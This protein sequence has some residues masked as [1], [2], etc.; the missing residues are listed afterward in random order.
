MPSSAFPLVDAADIVRLVGRGAYDRG[1]AYARGESVL[2][3][4]WKPDARAGA[5]P[6]E[7]GAA[8]EPVDESP[9]GSGGALAAEVVGTGPLPYLCRV[10]LTRMANGYWLPL[11]S[12]CSCPV[13]SN[14]KHVAATLLSSNQAHLRDLGHAEGGALAAPRAHLPADVGEGGARRLRALDGEEG[15]S[16]PDVAPTPA[17][18]PKPSPEPTAGPLDVESHADAAMAWDRGTE[19]YPSLAPAVIRRPEVD[20][21][22]WRAIVGGA[23]GAAN[24][25]GAGAAAT[26]RTGSAGRTRGGPPRPPTRMG[27]QFEVREFVPRTRE[28]WRGPASRPAQVAKSRDDTI[29]QPP[30]RLGVRPVIRSES[31][32]YIKA[33]VTWSS[34]THQV[35]RLNLEPEH[36]RWFAQF[37]AVHRATRELY[38]GHETDWLYLDEFT[39][40]L[41]WHLLDEGRALGIPLLGTKKSAVVTRGSEGAVRLDAT[42]APSGALQLAAVAVID[43]TAAP[44]QSVG[45]IGAHGVYTYELAPVPRVSIAPV[46]AGLS[47]QALALLERNTDIVVPGDEVGEFI[48]EFLPRLR[49]AIDVG[50]PDESV[51]LPEVMPPVLVL[52]AR[53]RAKSVLSL[54]WSWEYAVGPRA[55]RV[56]LYAAAGMGSRDGVEGGEGDAEDDGGV[57]RDPVTERETLTR[58]T[59]VLAEEPDGASIEALDSLGD[60]DAAAPEPLN[61]SL[62]LR[63]YD[64]AIFTD[65]TLPRLEGLPGVRVDV[66]GTRPDYRELTGEPELT[67]TTVESDKRD[68]F[69]LGV[70]VNVGG[71]QVPFGPLFKAL[72]KNQKKLLMVDKTYLT[73]DHPVFDQLREL[74]DEAS[75]L[76]EWETGVRISRYQASLW[77][78]FEELA[79]DTVQAVAWREAV[80]G[81]NGLKGVPKPEVPPGVHANLR[82]YQVEGYQWLAFLEQQRLG[83]VLA[84]D[85]GLGKTLQTLAMLARARA[86]APD[87]APFL[88][89]APTSVVSNWLAEAA[90]FTPGLVVRGITSTQAKSRRSVADAAAG[91]DVIVTSYAL[92]RLDA[93]AYRAVEWSGLIL[94]EAQFVK[95]H[96][97]KLH[98]CAKELDA[99]FKLAITGTP[100]ENNLMEL[101]SLFDIVAPGLFPSA[102][103]FTEEYVRPIERMLDDSLM[104]KLR[105][106]IRP[107]MM[108]RTKQLVA[109]ELP[110]KQEQVLQI[111][112]APAHRR[113]YDAFFQKERQKLLGLVDDLDKNRFIVFRS[114]TL[115]RMLSLDASLIDEKYSSIPSSKLDAL[116]EQ[117]GDVVAEGHR[118]LMFSQFTSFLG[119]A[120]AR[121][122]DAGIAFE[123]LDGSTRNRAQV[124]DG[125]K[126]G[127]APVFLISLKAGGFGL[128]LTE[129]DYVF[130]LDPWWNP[131]SESQAIDRTHR[132]GQTKSVNVYRLVA[133]DTIE[134]KVMALKEQKSK[135]FDA[136]MDD[137]AVFSSALTAADIRGLLE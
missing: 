136:V 9:T 82:P 123:Y 124:I 89:V 39:S 85:M 35:N 56:P 127:S 120:A 46:A 90:R 17:P 81:L 113:L 75:T 36:L 58:V 63:G 20:D 42:R 103:R 65:K 72:A 132:I 108:R 122:T 38:T 118:A 101:W 23:A 29:G 31:G 6:G 98:E 27:L 105:R 61:P 119:V 52:A 11:S 64:A 32:G 94:D 68:W 107:L 88:V 33:N 111:A 83:G 26:S 22:D 92:F 100:L 73:L 1:R 134:E 106:R 8:P 21:G 91:A 86:E 128:N 14:C 62:A 55:L 47:E 37:A 112:L 45:A 76:D 137:D 80:S 95:N 19:W 78:E 43:G 28:Q 117:L 130:L 87:A 48:D 116:L 16:A 5:E 54:D 50:S 34:F 84:D 30:R 66:A 97:S 44:R 49:R 121:L 41:L 129:A 40:P 12:T 67:F 77:S 125:F 102:G 79:E 110:A 131:A 51:A 126:S 3:L 71:Y 57:L 109:P 24:G 96:T 13:Q 53:F 25:A 93:A 60:L 104:P 4:R 74:L 133:Q 15:G 114:L 59:E 115:L 70:V 2:G 99:P 69:D 7:N 10:R 135:L 18:A